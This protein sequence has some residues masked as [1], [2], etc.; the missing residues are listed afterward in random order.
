M[1]PPLRPQVKAP[2]RLKMS[3]KEKKALEKLRAARKARGE[4]VTGE[5]QEG[6]GGREGCCKACFGRVCV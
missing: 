5:R 6:G 4:E 1:P 2:P 3:N